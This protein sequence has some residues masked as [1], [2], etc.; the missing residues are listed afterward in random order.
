MSLLKQHIN[1][2]QKLLIRNE[3]GDL[4]EDLSQKLD[5]GRPS[6][7]EVIL[8]YSTYKQHYQKEMKGTISK[9]QADLTYNKLREALLDIFNNLL[10]DDLGSGGS[11]ED[12]LDELLAT[13]KIRHPLSP[14]YI[15]NCDRKKN[16]RSFFRT[17]SSWDEQQNFQFYFAL[18]CPSQK[19]EGFAERMV[20]EIIERRL[21]GQ[22]DGIR[23]PRNVNGER[24]FIPDLP[25]GFNLKDCKENFCRY[26]AERFQL[27][28]QSFEEFMTKTLLK[29]RERYIAMPFNI[30]SGDWEPEL[31]EEYL[32]WIIETFST[33]E[34]HGPTCIFIFVIKLKN[35]HNPDNIRYEREVMDSVKDFIE[36]YKDIAGYLYPFKE[37]PQDFFEQWLEKVAYIR[38]DQIDQIMELLKRRFSEAELARYETEDQLLDM[39][40]IEQVQ[41]K[42]W[43]QGR[44][45]RAGNG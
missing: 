33:N 20:F 5:K 18:G 36:K 37:V 14:L 3:W 13:L 10:P 25:L 29:R 39:E 38:Q 19:P 31:M 8:H 12:P 16:F 22:T 32:P 17:F 27:G 34:Y 42:V 4:F 30:M 7:S 1:R 41:E 40:R 2:W 24:L 6:F 28:K 44:E 23:Y 45:T 43:K 11:L 35:A 9:E 15:V 26:M 21:Q